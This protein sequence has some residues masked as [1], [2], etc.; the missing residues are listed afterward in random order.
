METIAKQWCVWLIDSSNKLLNIEY[1]GSLE[2]CVVFVEISTYGYY[3]IMPYDAPA[4][5]MA[6]VK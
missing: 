5:K 4:D 6:G 2:D 1:K 3:G